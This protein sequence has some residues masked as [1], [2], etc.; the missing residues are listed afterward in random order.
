LHVWVIGQKPRRFHTVRTAVGD[1]AADAECARRIV[2]EECVVRIDSETLP[3][4][5][6]RVVETIACVQYDG[7]RF[8]CVGVAGKTGSY[9]R[10]RIVK[11]LRVAG[12]R[13][14]GNQTESVIQA[15]RIERPCAVPV[16]HGAIGLS[17]LR[18]DA[19]E[20]PKRMVQPRFDI[21]RLLIV[22]DCLRE[23]AGLPQ[24]VSQ[25]PVKTGR[26]A[27][28]ADCA[29]IER[30][31]RCV[32]AHRRSKQARVLPYVS[33]LRGDLQCLLQ[34]AASLLHV[35]GMNARESQAMQRVSVAWTHAEHL[36]VSDDCLCHTPGGKM[37]VRA[38][39][40]RLD[41]SVIV[42]ETGDS[43]NQ[44]E[45]LIQACRARE[46]APAVRDR[47]GDVIPVSRSYCV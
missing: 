4:D 16:V 27:R 22:N 2:M 28:K 11:L 47:G 14:Y 10:D 24:A 9:L 21:N 25:I 19:G 36:P 34:V 41:V 43:E 26:T 7:E 13:E 42:I 44:K 45:V 12:L 46:V 8:Q 15:V 31:S 29:P 33:P 39:D 1:S 5:T 17:K 23:V 40:E 3:C 38:R 37:R 32:I 35:V 18:M 6:E 30:F 20:R